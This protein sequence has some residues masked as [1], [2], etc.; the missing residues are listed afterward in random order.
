MVMIAVFVLSGLVLVLLVLLAVRSWTL[1]QNRVEDAM[2]EPGAV[3]LSYAVPPGQDPAALTAALMEA[4]FTCAADL[5]AGVDRVLVACPDDGDRAEI[6]RVI[7]AVHREGVGGP[8]APAGQVRF[9]D[10][11]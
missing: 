7:E 5:D 3:T 9:D 6:R 2:R 1:R 11:R 4:G 8:G 10:E